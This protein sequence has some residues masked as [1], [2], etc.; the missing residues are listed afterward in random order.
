M[1]LF[2]LDSRSLAAMVAQY[3]AEVIRDRV[4]AEEADPDG[5]AD[6][7]SHRQFV[8]M[9]ASTRIRV[10]GPP[11]NR[12]VIAEPGI[13]PDGD[14]WTG[15]AAEIV[16]QAADRV[17]TYLI[18]SWRT[19]SRPWAVALP[20][21]EI[22]GHGG[23]G[24]RLSWQHKPNAERAFYR[25]PYGQAPMVAVVFEGREYFLGHHT[26]KL[27]VTVANRDGDRHTFSARV[28]AQS[29]RLLAR[30]LGTDTYTARRVAVVVVPDRCGVA[31]ERNQ[32][33][34]ILSAAEEAQ[35]RRAERVAA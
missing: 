3:A 31:L 25:W 32:A 20:D 6:A 26:Q 35:Q 33:L 19:P 14:Y 8:D 12:S 21:G 22:T 1:T 23:H 17:H 34:R 7:R 18:E 30:S 2:A 11:W 5:W 29:V 4:A 10:A 9:I 16:D 13:V 15:T 24:A 27:A 28:H